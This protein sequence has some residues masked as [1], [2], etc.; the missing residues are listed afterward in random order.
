MNTP[1]ISIIIPAYNIEFYLSKT[2][3]SVLKQT[4][5]NI[6]IILVNDGS[7]DNTMK[8]IDE[9]ASNDSRIIPIHKDNGGVTSARLSGIQA[10]NGEWIGFVDGDDY[11]E[12]D[13]YERLMNNAL[14]YNA[15]ISHCG[16]QMILPSGKIL[17]HY[18]TKRIVVHNN[19]QGLC[20]LISGSFIEPGL[21]N[22]LYKKSLFHTILEND[23]MD[24][25]IKNT[26]DLLMNYYLFK[27]SNCAI[28]EDFCPYHY[29]LRKN[30]AANAPINIHQLEDPLKVKRILFNDTTQFSEIHSTAANVLVRQLISLATMCDKSNPALIKPVKKSALKELRAMLGDIVSSQKYSKKIKISA[31]WVS[32]FPSTYR[33]VHSLYE[34][35]NGLDNIYEK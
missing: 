3:D 1:L 23:L 4:Y 26:E 17:Y 28:F 5:K 27:E 24:L 2:L 32:V 16:Y 35:I 30:S 13:M 33:W 34:R 25:S 21:W 6:E 18:N 11:I 22:K 9:Y 20:D 31:I 29:I 14:Q 8:I 12:P 7:T 19:L 10:A 15:D